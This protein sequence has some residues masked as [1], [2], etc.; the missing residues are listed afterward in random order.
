MQR[1]N[2]SI[3][4]LIRSEFQGNQGSMQGFAGTTEAESQSHR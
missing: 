1:M 4:P 3:P 2:V